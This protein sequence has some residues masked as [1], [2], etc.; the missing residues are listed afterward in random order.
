[1]TTIS[2]MLELPIPGVSSINWESQLRDLAHDYCPDDIYRR[3]S[4]FDLSL[5]GLGPCAHR[6]AVIGRAR[7]CFEHEVL[8][9]LNFCHGRLC[10]V[11]QFFPSVRTM[12]DHEYYS[13]LEAIRRRLSKVLGVPSLQCRTESDFQVSFRWNRDNVHAEL[14]SCNGSGK[15]LS[16]AVNNPG[17]C[18]WCMYWK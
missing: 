3:R 9:H 7:H 2:D 5:F 11:H 18:A 1:M 13:A 15:D 17:V 6:E 10:A 8:T 12:E 4:R 14:R 16:L